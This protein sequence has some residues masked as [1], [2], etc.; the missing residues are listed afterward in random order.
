MLRTI[1]S[2][3]AG[4]L[5]FII[6]V[7]LTLMTLQIIMRYGFNSSLLWAEEM[8]RYMLIWLAF[9]GVAMSYERGEVAALTFISNSL[10]R[11]PALILAMVTAGLS[12]MLCLLLVWYGWHFANLAGS[13]RI[14]AMRFILDD[15]FGADAPDAPTIFWI[16]VALPFGLAL[17]ALRLGADIVLCGRALFS[18]MTLAEALDRRTGSPTE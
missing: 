6:G 10:S 18:G 8:C 5:V 17:V 12:L 15:I 9:L 2:A 16:Y 14:P 3:F 11:R 7:L 4:T 1:R 13:S